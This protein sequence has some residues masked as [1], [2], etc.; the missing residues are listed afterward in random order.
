MSCSRDR[1]SDEKAISRQPAVSEGTG[2]KRWPSECDTVKGE[3][4]L[5]ILPWVGNWREWQR[6]AEGNIASVQPCFPVSNEKSAV[7]V[8]PPPAFLLVW[9]KAKL[10]STSA[11]LW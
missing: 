7:A 5:Y 4:G 9:G 8:E 3:L 10:I 11:L 2:R 1:K 6:E